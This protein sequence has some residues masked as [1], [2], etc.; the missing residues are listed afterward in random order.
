MK[1]VGLMYHDV[2]RA[3]E[4]E[5]SG[6]PGAW[7]AHY[8]L[9][10]EAFRRHLE[11]LAASAAGRRITTIHA[12]SGASDQWPVFLTFDDG[13]VSAHDA[14]ADRLETFG[15]RGHF[16]M[17]TD[18]INQP[19]FLTETQLRDLHQRGHVIGSHSRSHPTRMAACP[20][21]QLLA[22][23]RDSLAR[24][25]D[26]T[27]AALDTASVPGGYYSEAVGRAASQAGLRILFTSE[28]TVNTHHVGDCLV[29]G[30]YA[31][32]QGM[33]SDVAVRIACGE[34]GPRA[35]QSGSWIIK[36]VA[37]AAGGRVYLAAGRLLR[38]RSPKA[39]P[40]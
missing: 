7:A 37:K 10:S 39:S 9:E 32:T 4:W 12:V 34:F 13:G 5:A 33:S 24:L 27:G 1:A 28:P 16:F 25:R 2:V 19:G 31:M 21:D 22:E 35:W 8:K 20:T 40:R 15:W 14:I 26:I 38:A 30:R 11:G 6:F 36:K 23:W 3:G 18:W 17:T 29:L